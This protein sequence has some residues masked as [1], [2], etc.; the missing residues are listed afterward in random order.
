MAYGN[1]RL[2]WDSIKCSTGFSIRGVL[3]TATPL[4][5]LY[6]HY[7]D[8]VFYSNGNLNFKSK[9]RKLLMKC[10]K[11]SVGVKKVSSLKDGTFLY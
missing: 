4:V 10:T 3:W 1:W 5:S 8:W 2:V 6:C 7:S 11:E 9:G